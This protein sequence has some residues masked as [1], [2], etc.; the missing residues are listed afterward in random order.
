MILKEVFQKIS[1]WH[2]NLYNNF[3]IFVIIE[4]SLVVL[5]I[6]FIV[7]YLTKRKIKNKNKINL[8]KYRSKEKTDLDV[9]YDLLKEKKGLKVSTIS[10][11]FKIDKEV[12]MEW[13]KILESGNMATIEYPALGETIIKIKENKEENVSNN[14]KGELKIKNTEEKESKTKNIEE[15]ESKTKKIKEKKTKTKKTKE[16]K[17]KIKKIKEKKTKTKKIKEK[18]TKTK[19][20]IKNKPIKKKLAIPKKNKEVD[21]GEI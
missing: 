9:L 5:A 3:H 6:F 2:S 11:L 18:K 4:W 12:T 7:L 10:N 19:N 15:K 8:N 13:G 20:L 1:D 17:T 16:K 14:K 21:F